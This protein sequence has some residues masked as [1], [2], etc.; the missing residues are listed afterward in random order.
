MSVICMS[1]YN[2]TYY[3]NNK[4]SFKQSRQKYYNKNKDE[5]LK[6]GKQ[7]RS[8]HKEEER[9]KRHKRYLENIDKSKEYSKMYKRQHSLPDKNGNIVSGV[10][11]RMYPE[12][13]LCE[14][15]HGKNKKCKRLL[16][17]H[18]DD[19]HMEQGI[20]MCGFCHGIAESIDSMNNIQ[21]VINTYITIK[22][23]IIMATN[24]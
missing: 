13:G 22:E 4:E 19:N 18:W 3:E 16:Y 8:E 23:N 7:W 15:C 12:D 6:R 2:K 17:H 11:K 21:P 14:L 10:N 20:W 5:C 1:T 9:V 24:D